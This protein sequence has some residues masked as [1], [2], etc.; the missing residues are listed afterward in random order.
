MK[1]MKDTILKFRDSEKN[2][3]FL[4]ISTLFTEIENSYVVEIWDVNKDYYSSKPLEITIKKMEELLKNNP[5]HYKAD[6]WKEIISLR[7][8]GNKR[9]LVEKEKFN[10]TFLIL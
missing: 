3:P 7:K 5:N 10:E 8:Y 4:H 6:K 2:K 1:N 9:I